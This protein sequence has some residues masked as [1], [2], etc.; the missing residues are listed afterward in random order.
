M[1]AN[2]IHLEMNEIFKAICWWN[3]HYSSLYLMLLHD[4]SMRALCFHFSN[5]YSLL[6]DF[7]QPSPNFYHINTLWLV[8]NHKRTH[9]NDNEVVSWQNQIILPMNN[10]AA[11][12]LAAKSIDW[13]KQKHE[14]RE[15]KS[16]MDLML[17][18]PGAQHP[19]TASIKFALDNRLE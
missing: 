9:T 11:F 15:W 7:S 8:K 14:K 6:G 12:L 16:W 4:K 2:L 10:E 5:V 19:Q 1:F 3:F 13:M 17:E 18:P